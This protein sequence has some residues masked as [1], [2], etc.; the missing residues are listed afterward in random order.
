MILWKLA[1]LKKKKNSDS[2]TVPVPPWNITSVQIQKDRSSQSA[3]PSLCT[4]HQASLGLKDSSPRI[5]CISKPWFSWK[6]IMICLF[7]NTVY[8][9][10]L[11]F[12]KILLEFL[13][14]V[15]LIKMLCSVSK[16]KTPFAGLTEQKKYQKY[17]LPADEKEMDT[18]HN[19]LNKS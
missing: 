4:Y 12:C 17:V 6:E 11:G 9:R 3:A 15:I 13:S 19:S 2:S 5:F 7:Q 18:S 10:D 14:N 16:E 8:R 1:L